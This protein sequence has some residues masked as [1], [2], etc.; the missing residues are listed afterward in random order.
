MYKAEMDHEKEKKEEIEDAKDHTKPKNMFEDI[1]LKSAH[2]GVFRL[3]KE[4]ADVLNRQKAA[5]PVEEAAPVDDEDT[6]G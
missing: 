3:P 1:S 4:L 2:D 5:E 6:L